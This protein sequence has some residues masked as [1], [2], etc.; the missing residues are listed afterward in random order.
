MTGLMDRETVKLEQY[1]IYAD[2]VYAFEDR[3]QITSRLFVTLNMAVISALAYGYSSEELNLPFFSVIGLITCAI[4]FCILWWLI[5][6]S[7]TRHTTAK[8]EV[9]QDMEQSLPFKPYTDEWFT[10]L[11]GGKNYI[12]TT[13]LHEIFPW[14]FV[15]AYIFLAI[16][17]FFAMLPGAESMP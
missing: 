8:H 4:T 14:I 6:R 17:R 9:L 1:R 10:K 7:I 12:R 5:L 15:M 13:T 3:A 2:S 16:T 11:Q